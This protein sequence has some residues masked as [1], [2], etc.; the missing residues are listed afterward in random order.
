MNQPYY[1]RLLSRIP[2]LRITLT[3]IAGIISTQL[4]SISYSSAYALFISLVAAYGGVVALMH[5]KGYRWGSF[6]GVLGLAA[7]YM[8]GYVAYLQQDPSYQPYHFSRYTKPISAYQGVV[9]DRIVTKALGDETILSIRQVKI[10]GRW[11]VASGKV[12]VVFPKGKAT[13]LSYGTILAIEGAPAP[14]KQSTNPNVPNYNRMRYSHGI[15]HKHHPKRWSI[16]GRRAS[17]PFFQIA[18]AGQAYFAKQLRTYI[19]DPTTLGLTL[20]LVLG[21]KG[22]LKPE[23]KHSYMRSGV[24]H[25]LSISGLHIGMLYGL[26]LL[27]FYLLSALFGRPGNYPLVAVILL[28]GYALMTGLSPAVLR[29]ISTLSLVVL[30]RKYQKDYHIGNI[31]G[32]VAFFSLLYNPNLL[33]D[34]GF[35][36]SFTAVTGILLCYLPMLRRYSVKQRLLRYCWQNTALSLVA[37]VSTLPLSLYYFHYFALY[38]LPANCIMIPLATIHLSLSGLLLLISFWPWGATILAKLITKATLMGDNYLRWLTELPYAY[39]GPFMPSIGVVIGC[40][41]TLISLYLGFQKRS[42]RYLL[43]S[44]ILICLGSAQTIYNNAQHRAQRFAIIYNL[45]SSQ[46]IAFIVGNKAALISK[47]PL[48]EN[49]WDYTK[50]VKPSL[51][52]RKITHIKKYLYGNTKQYGC[53]FNREPWLASYTWQGK[54]F[55]LLDQASST[56]PPPQVLPAYIDVL[57]V[58]EAAVKDLTPWLCATTIGLVVI[59]G[60]GKISQDL[61]DQAAAFG[62]RSHSL[63]SQGA[64]ILPL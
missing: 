22:A 52:A 38:G 43:F 59:E 1:S 58:Q 31:L 13:S 45:P 63:A 60:E 51:V 35:Q 5:Y 26:L 47:K 44:T 37:Q 9:E 61:A 11:Q 7:L 50:E 54:T 21:D 56:L 36:L 6:I 16:Q 39:L 46:A 18:L 42:F 8:G 24:M 23:I 2:F 17:N 33:F 29:A 34:V 40:Y 4:F 41:A 27:L 53:F 12:K 64:C 57:I 49:A 32:V 55:G 48:Y 10:V 19:K 3:F 20:A 28:W 14:L 62:V 30:A 25:I 15:F